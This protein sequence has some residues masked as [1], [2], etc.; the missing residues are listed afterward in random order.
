MTEK[1]LTVVVDGD[2]NGSW[3]DQTSLSFLELFK[4]PDDTNWDIRLSKGLEYAQE[5]NHWMVLF[6]K[7]GVAWPENDIVDFF[8]MAKKVVMDDFFLF[9]IG[10]TSK[11]KYHLENKLFIVEKINNLEA[12]IVWRPLFSPLSYMLSQYNL[13]KNIKQTSIT[14]FFNSYFTE[15]ITWNNISIEK[16]AN[17]FINIIVPFRNVENYLKD[18]VTSILN[19]KYKKFRIY[20]IDDCSS[21]KSIEQIPQDDHIVIIRNNVRKYSLKNICDT[22]QNID[23]GDDD[24]ICLVDG[25]DALTHNYVLD[26]INDCY[27]RTDCLITYG[28]YKT[29]TEHI[30]VGLEYSKREFQSLREVEWKATHLKTFSYKLFRKLLEYDSNL[31]CMRDEN[32]EFYWMPSD[33]ALMFPLLEAASYERAKFI[34]SALYLYR[35]HENNDQFE[36][37]NVQWKGE[38]AIRKKDKIPQLF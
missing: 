13:N 33:M 16:K 11:N 35:I 24:I 20:L 38:L 25:D 5:Q 19:Q 32:G 27:E 23:M 9:F 29:Y 31:N 2:T 34:N 36:N 21:D 3:L 18:C 10:T 4:L 7:E 1:I 6:M 37:R 14:D 26:I 12:F 28:S 30:Y 15:K 8:E 17:K 22:I